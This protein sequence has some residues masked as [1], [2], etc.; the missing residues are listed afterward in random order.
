MDTKGKIVVVL[1][2]IG[3]LA[4]VSYFVYNFLVTATRSDKLYLASF[5]EDGNTFFDCTTSPSKHDA[6]DDYSIPQ[7][8]T[9]DEDNYEESLQELKESCMET[10][11]SMGWRC[12]DDRCSN[13]E[14]N[15]ADPYFRMTEDDC[16]ENICAIDGSY[17][18]DD[19]EC[20]LDVNKCYVNEVDGFEG[21]II[22]SGEK[23]GVA[24]WRGNQSCLQPNM[25]KIQDDEGNHCLRRDCTTKDIEDGKC[26]TTQEACCSSC[27]DA[28]CSVSP[29][30]C[31]HYVSC[32]SYC[33]DDCAPDSEE[34]YRPGDCL[35]NCEGS[36]CSTR[37]QDSCKLFLNDERDADCLL[38]CN[39]R[40][41]CIIGFEPSTDCISPIDNGIYPTRTECCSHCS[42]K[43]CISRCGSG[44]RMMIQ[45]KLDT[46]R[47]IDSQIDVQDA[48]CSHT[49]L[50][51]VSNIPTS[52]R[53][54]ECVSLVRDT[55]FLEKM[56]NVNLLN[57][58]THPNVLSTKTVSLT[59][60]QLDGVWNQIVNSL[61]DEQRGWNI[62]GSEKPSDNIISHENHSSIS[63]ITH[64][65]INRWRQ[66]F[67]L[68]YTFQ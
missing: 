38:D 48:Q 43:T 2:I 60:S 51:S 36:S 55:E 58:L 52:D 31:S 11:H 47:P 28:T 10:Y 57:E 19:G 35:V 25:F 24:C 27:V 17:Y 22:P 6:K 1:L 29:S 14:G 65:D 61:S 23:P 54:I 66:R 13:V 33:Q 53:V 46:S 44:Y 45:Y 37:C 18:D 8:W 5:K 21:V 56:D 34:C 20:K 41:Q 64:E 62:L 32:S 68:N 50:T 26:F 9:I 7:K 49:H 3:L 59:I 16:I 40:W 30:P 39:D 15:L 4:T 42:S 67:L 63:N 12:S